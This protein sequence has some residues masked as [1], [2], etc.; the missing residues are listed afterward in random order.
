MRLRAASVRGS[1]FTFS[2]RRV[3]SSSGSSPSSSRM[4]RICCCRKYSRCCSSSSLCVRS[5]ISCFSRAN[6]TSRPNSFSS[7]AARS[8]VSFSII[9]VALSVIDRD[10]FVQMKCIAATGCF[11]LR[12]AKMASSRGGSYARNNSTV[13]SRTASIVARN[14]VSPSGGSISS[15]MDTRARA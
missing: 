3:A 13:C 14:V 15:H 2:R 4:Q 11:T 5:R 7:A 12:R 10:R 9:S 8:V 1:C 6:C